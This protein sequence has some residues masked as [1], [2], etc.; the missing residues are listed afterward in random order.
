MADYDTETA[1]LI[2]A[3][4]ARIATL[5]TM[6]SS[7]VLMTRHGDTMV[8]FQTIKDLNA[9]IAAEVKD[10]KRL[11]GESRTPVYSFQRSKGL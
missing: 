11:K 1:A 9:A 7:G 2:A 5:K 8:Q 3:A 6:R 4:E 10:L